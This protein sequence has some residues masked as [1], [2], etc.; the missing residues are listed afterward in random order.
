M[1]N[2]A[3]FE[4]DLGDPATKILKELLDSTPIPELLYAKS[5][6]DKWSFEVVAGMANIDGNM[7]DGFEVKITRKSPNQENEYKS[8]ITFQTF[9]LRRVAYKKLLIQSGF[10]P[11]DTASVLDSTNDWSIGYKLQFKKG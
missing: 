6:L 5:G 10:I 1:V 2:K 8:L 3:V 11:D 7:V 4:F 9:E